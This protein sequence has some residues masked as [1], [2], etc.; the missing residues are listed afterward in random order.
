MAVIAID[1]G[2]TGC[3]AALFEGSRMLGW[4]YRHLSYTSPEDGWAEQDA[5][6]VWRLVDQTVRQALSVCE[7]APPVEAIGVSVQGDAVIP[8][9][10]EGHALQPAILGM[11]TRSAQ[12][13]ADLQ[14]QFGRGQL[15]SL[16]GM[17]CEPLN[18]VTKMA[19]LVR[20]HPEMRRRVWKYAH[21]GEF[22][23]MKL[24]G[25]P[26]LDY[27]MAS[28]TMAFDPVRK[29]WVPAILEF[30]G[31]TPS[32][33]GNLSPS[34][35][36]VGIVLRH[37]AD[38]WGISRSALVITGGHDQCM[39][40][41]GAGVIE[42]DLACYSM[43][44]AEVIG[45]CFPFPRAN[46]AML[47]ANYPSYCHAVASQY[48]TITLNQSGGLSLEW[49]RNNVMELEQLPEDAGAAVYERL[50]EEVEIKPS[51]VLFLPHLVGS[52]TPTCDHLSRGAF[53]GLSL[54]TGRRDMFQ[55]VVDALAFEARLNL[56]KLEDLD[57]HVAELRAVGGGTR[58][59]RILELKATVLNRPIRTLRNPE[60]ALLGAAILAQ[61]AIGRF[62]SIEE[63]CAECVRIDLTVEPRKDAEE[64][65]SAAFDRYRQVYTTL[66]S[67]YHNWRA[68]CRTAVLV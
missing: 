40:A 7:T 15:Y 66:R 26:A 49:F 45:T 17:P 54:K 46:S 60:A 23:L 56:E 42:P 57:I 19:W 61:V 8:I 34:G 5:E 51:P 13:A 21:Y 20:N 41:V 38:V 29:D 24:A 44:T 48:F 22:L 43:G 62:S 11:D 55:A 53:L 39:A 50:S 3:K 68:E 37:V 58:S 65:Y 63:A 4:A 35:A 28:R 6:A 36:P 30:V 47:A 33:L 2:T 18:A 25:V 52:G 9:D 1:L 64:L 67:F 10:H 31:I 59:R 32:E 14:E 27:T 16:T 12:E